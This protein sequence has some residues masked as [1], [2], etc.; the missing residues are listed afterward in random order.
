[1]ERDKSLFSGYR[2]LKYS[3]VKIM[4]PLFKAGLPLF[5]LLML[6]GCSK[7]E[8]IQLVRNGRTDHTICIDPSAPGSV[9]LA[10]EEL[11]GYFKR[12]T[13]VSPGIIET[14]QVPSTPYISLGNTAAARAAGLDASGI[15]DDG[16]RIVT[17][18]GN[19]FILGPDTPDGRVNDLGGG[20]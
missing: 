12:V 20:K 1:M 4:K 10:A 16:F 9:R 8:E 18:G 17:G 14:G 5:V 7:Q 2:E 6:Y 15:T 3:F 19:V 13:G 11:T